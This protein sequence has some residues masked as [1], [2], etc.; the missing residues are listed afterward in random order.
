MNDLICPISFI[1][2]KQAK[3]TDLNDLFIAG[4]RDKVCNDYSHS[5]LL[6][7]I[8]NSF[9][10]SNLTPDQ[11]S[12]LNE[13]RNYEYDA[14]SDAIT[15]YLICNITDLTINTLILFM[16]KLSMPNNLI[17][18]NLDQIV[19]E[20]KVRDVVAST[21]LGV[22]GRSFVREDSFEQTFMSIDTKM[23]S[24]YSILITKVFDAYVEAFV[25]ATAKCSGLK[26]LFET[27]YAVVYKSTDYPK[28]QSYSNMYVFCST[29]LREAM[30]NETL[31]YRCGLKNI[32]ETATM[33]IKG[34]PKYAMNSM[35]PNYLTTTEEYNNC[36]LFGGGFKMPELTIGTENNEEE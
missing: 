20:I 9:D 5:L 13:I 16:Q 32:A 1:N 26:E 11:S 12:W 8:K 29:I 15:S 22:F 3:S 7:E 2:E 4:F 10:F 28:N 21:V 23:G 35:N 27:L 34:S 6:D 14:F 30:D 17:D 24:V 33:M 31:N 25:S 18:V 19:N 36:G